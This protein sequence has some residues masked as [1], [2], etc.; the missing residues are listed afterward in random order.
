[1]SPFA[2]DFVAH[3]LRSVNDAPVA[4]VKRPVALNHHVR[5]LQQVLRVD[6]PEVALAGPDGAHAHLVDQTRG[7]HLATD[8]TSGD[9][10]QAVTRKR[11]RLDHGCLDAVDEAKRR[12]GVP[13]RG[14][15]R[16]VTTT[17]W[18]MPPG[19]FPPQPSVMSKTWRPTIAAPI[20][21]QYGR[22]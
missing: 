22:V 16:C 15:G 1:M 18:S 4:Q 13:A 6:R 8:L 2:V 3:P 11:L 7:K 14:S 5:I 19:G 17:T 10:D 21:S 9:L 12:L 20:R